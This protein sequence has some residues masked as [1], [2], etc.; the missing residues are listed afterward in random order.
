[1]YLKKGSY[2]KYI[3]K[4]VPLAL[5]L[6]FVVSCVNAKVI[7]PVQTSK[8]ETINNGVPAKPTK[9]QKTKKAKKTQ[10]E[11]KKEDIVKAIEKKHARKLGKWLRKKAFK[12]DD[13]LTANEETALIVAIRSGDET[14]RIARL[15]LTKG[16]DVTLADK[17][18]V[19]P[20]DLAV[21]MGKAVLVKKMVAKYEVEKF[22]EVLERNLKAAQEKHDQMK[23][24]KKMKDARRYKAIVRQLKRALGLEE[25]KVKK[26]R[27]PKKA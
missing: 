20:L 26:M 13:R 9:K 3:V 21:K 1:M 4:S 14:M 2:M 15:F 27:K 11:V 25:K 16:A 23:K 5:G 6:L 10:K 12:I 18:G 8:V 22:K 19:T 7:E 24:D 17:E